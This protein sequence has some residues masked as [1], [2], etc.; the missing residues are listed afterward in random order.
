MWIN[1]SASGSKFDEG[2]MQYFQFQ[3]S[4]LTRVLVHCHCLVS[5]FQDDFRSCLPT[6]LKNLLWL[7]V[8]ISKVIPKYVGRNLHSSFSLRSSS[9]TFVV[10][11]ETFFPRDLLYFSVCGEMNFEGLEGDRKKAALIKEIK[12]GW[13]IAGGGGGGGGTTLSRGICFLTIV[14]HN[15]VVND[16]RK[17][18]Y[19]ICYQNNNMP[20]N[21]QII[22][23]SHTGC[24]RKSCPFS[25]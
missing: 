15:K 13:N 6:N 4:D 12:F 14:M 21:C 2:E 20:N 10:C 8:V 16:Q 9:Q 7:T 3:S 24:P 19:Q 22:R 23:Q 5:N 1:S 25:K 11:V 18:F 17:P